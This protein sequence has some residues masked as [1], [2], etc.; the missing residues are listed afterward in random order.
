MT[1]TRKKT[2]GAN[3][4]QPVQTEFNKQQILASKRYANKRD[5][6]DALLIDDQKYTLETVDKLLDKFMKG[7]VN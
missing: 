1:T 3:D 2:E 6:V 7:K 4:V 5:L